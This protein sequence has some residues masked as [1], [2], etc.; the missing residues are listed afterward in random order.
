MMFRR[1]DARGQSLV[2][3]ALILPILVLM[4]TGFFDLGRVVL[5]NDALSHAARPTRGTR[6]F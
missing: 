2:E 6:W 4:L 3:T 5:A 1:R